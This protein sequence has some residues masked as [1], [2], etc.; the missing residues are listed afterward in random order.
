[1][2]RRAYIDEIPIGCRCIRRARSRGSPVELEVIFE[3][4]R[5]SRGLKSTW[6]IS[7]E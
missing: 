5:D 6:E 4:A 2:I 1:M 3:L 7:E